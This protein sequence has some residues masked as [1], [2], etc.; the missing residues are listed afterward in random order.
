MIQT[1]VIKK[2]CD[3]IRA[4][5]PDTIKLPTDPNT[6]VWEF[7][8]DYVSSRGYAIEILEL[9]LQHDD[10]SMLKEIVYEF[11][12]F[13]S[14]TQADRERAGF[15]AKLALK[16]E[17]FLKGISNIIYDDPLN[18]YDNKFRDLLERIFSCFNEGWTKDSNNK[19][20]RFIVYVRE[21]RH[22]E[23]HSVAH[24]NSLELAWRTVSGLAL[25]LYVIAVNFDS[26]ASNLLPKPVYL[27]RNINF[28]NEYL[29]RV[30]I[31]AEIPKVFTFAFCR[32]LTSGNLIDY[33]HVIGSINTTKS[34]LPVLIT[35]SSG[36]GKTVLLNQIA[37]QIAEEQLQLLKNDERI[38]IFPIIFPLS[39]LPTENLDKALNNII[40]YIFRPYITDIH[41]IMDIGQLINAANIRWLICL[42]GLDEVNNWEMGIRIIRELVDSYPNVNWVTSCNSEFLRKTPNTRFFEYQIIEWTDEV[43]DRFVNT[44]GGVL[45]KAD[46]KLWLRQSGL[47]QL[48]RVPIHLNSVV[49]LWKEYEKLLDIDFENHRVKYGHNPSSV[50]PFRAIDE[51]FN[52]YFEHYVSKLSGGNRVA[53]ESSLR[54]SLRKLAYIADGKNEV[55]I[56][57]AKEIVKDDLDLLIRMGWISHR[58]QTISFNNELVKLQL[59]A[60]EFG[61]R[62]Y[63][64]FEDSQESIDL[65]NYIQHIHGSKEFWTRCLIHNHEVMPPDVR[66]SENQLYWTAFALKAS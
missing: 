6:I 41:E 12:R 26:L 45:L 31:N 52:D 33:E 44:Y 50:S 29:S 17:P 40:R 9:L 54:E 8:I 59:A 63:K 64:I 46:L 15:P 24:L 53:Y 56:D 57:R 19:L 20:N 47:Q 14:A 55:S 35:A 18:K 65:K 30:I 25:Y 39:E 23:S 13:T 27:L 32:D 16:F 61:W 21:L 48:I 66:L 42:D 38:T 51:I 36:Q 2:F 43:I 62:L 60:R 58:E 11:D 28:L 4:E 37:L 7:N 1:D 34:I 3:F 22:V 49:K 5:V 10:F